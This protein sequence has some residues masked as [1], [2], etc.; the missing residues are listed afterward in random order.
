MARI[1][2]DVREEA[3][4]SLLAGDSQYSV[5][6]RLGISASTVNGIAAELVRTGRMA[7]PAD[8]A[9]TKNATAA[10]LADMASRRSRLAET[11]LERAEALVASL[12]QPHT[13]YNF[14]GKDNTYNS[15]EHP[16]PDVKSSQIIMTTAAIALDK[17]LAILR[18]DS[19]S[20]VDEAAGL[21]GALVGAMR[22]RYGDGSS[23][24]EEEATAD[25]DTTVDVHAPVS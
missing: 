4:R 2:D 14:G 7:S 19:G 8:R 21:L 22:Q 25:G 20:E 16:R 10:R 17:H 9:H 18:F 23:H 1:A 11:L 5:S 13:A 15:V 12:D 6:K 3:E 24:R